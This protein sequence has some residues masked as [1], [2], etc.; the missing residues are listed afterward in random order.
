MLERQSAIT[1][2][3]ARGGRRPKGVAGCRLGEVRGWSLLQVAGWPGSISE[4]ERVVTGAFGVG[5]PP[6]VGV[7]AHSDD[8][9]LLR[10]GPEQIWI[11]GPGETLAQEAALRSQLNAATG[12]ISSLSH[13]RTWMFLEGARARDVLAKGIAIDLSADVFAVNR[14]AMTGLDH[15]PVLLHRTGAD[16]YEIIAMRT[17]ALT[18]WDWLTDAALEFGYEMET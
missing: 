3:L 7:A 5:V 1:S 14:F 15:T 6:K 13:S 11:F 17:F 8:A 9:T 10:T 16:R 4:V 12:V 2:G 18:V